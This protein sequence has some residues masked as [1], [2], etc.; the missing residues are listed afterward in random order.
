MKEWAFNQLVNLTPDKY[1]NDRRVVRM[2]EMGSPS[3]AI[4]IVAREIGAD[5]TILGTHDYGPV[6]K[7]LLG[8]TTDRLLTKISSP[9]L[10]VSY[11]DEQHIGRRR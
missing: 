6:E 3:D 4:A 9:V 5:L 8:A 10:T 2:V 7:S 1:I 11:S